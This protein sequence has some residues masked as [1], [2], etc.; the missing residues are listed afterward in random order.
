MNTQGTRSPVAAM[1]KD[2]SKPI[3]RGPGLIAPFQS[4]EPAPSPRC[5][6]PTTPVARPARLSIAGRVSRPGSMMRAASP[7]R[8]L[9]PF[10]RH[11]YSPV[12]RA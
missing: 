2:S 10:R 6:L 5:H 7:G 12:K 1:M 4:I 3:S 9:V 11:A 8:T